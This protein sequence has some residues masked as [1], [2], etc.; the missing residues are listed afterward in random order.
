VS[1]F[2]TRVALLLEGAILLIV[3]YGHLLQEPFFDITTHI[4]PRLVLL[5]FLLVVPASV[6][7]LSIDH[8][9]RTR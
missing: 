3:T 2:L 5:V 1:G 4:F 7:R 8:W 6:D 9:L